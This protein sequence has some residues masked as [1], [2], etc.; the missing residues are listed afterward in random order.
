[1]PQKLR[2]R[3]LECRTRQR[4]VEVT[5]IRTGGFFSRDYNI[6]SC[7]AMYD[8][9]AGCDRNCKSQLSM[10]SRFNQC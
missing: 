3:I 2:T 5:Y 8:N 9:V 7:P 1:M 4:E 10:G 6:V